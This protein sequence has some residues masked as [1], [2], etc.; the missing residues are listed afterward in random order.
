MAL[1]DLI[2]RRQSDRKY[3]PSRQVPRELLEQ[4]V[5]AAHWAPSA[6][7]GQPW[8]FII[9]DEPELKAEVAG[10]LTSPLVGKMNHFAKEASAL[11]VVVEEPSNVAGR[12]GSL[13]LQ[14]HL[15]HIDVGIAAAHLTLAATELGLGSCIM[16]WVNQK[17]IQKALSLPKSRS[18]PLVISVGY[19]LE[20]QKAKKRKRMEE[21]CSWNEY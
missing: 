5:E 18:V 21:I 17:K 3:D 14:N 10:A 2:K 16:G 19:S 6:T 9:V 12:V 4:V 20:A 15:P 8:H 11:I 13:L 7:N 1:I